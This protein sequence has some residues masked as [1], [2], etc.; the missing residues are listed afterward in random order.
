MPLAARREDML[1][2][3]EFPV[4]STVT[5]L[6]EKISLSASV[7]S[8]VDS[9]WLAEQRQRK[10]PLFNGS[11]VSAVEILPV[12]I[13]G[14]AVEYRHWVAQR[15]RPELFDVL[16]VRPIAVSGL[17]ECADGTVFGRRG[18]EMMQDAGLWELVPSGGL[19]ARN[20]AAGEVDYRA[21]C[22][23]ELR[24]EI[25]IDSDQVSSVRPFCLVEDLDAHVLDIG[26]AMESALVAD[27]VLRAHRTAASKEYDELRVVP[28]AALAEFGRSESSQ[29]VR[30]SAALLARFCRGLA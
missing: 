13:L 16:H 24:E 2:I 7:E 15:A 21:Q 28:R 5:L 27:A 17:L 30:V 22:M 23:M 29:L 26:V 6:E 18:V 25:G 14:R 19:D 11:I 1:T 10:V 20:R 12:G 8:E 3:R 4:T 9:L